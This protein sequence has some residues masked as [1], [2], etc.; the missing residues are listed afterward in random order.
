MGWRRTGRRLQDAEKALGRPFDATIPDDA[1][2]VIE[3]ENDGLP[4]AQLKRK[5]KVE[6]A[7]K[8]S[9]EDILSEIEKHRAS[10]ETQDG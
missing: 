8:N 10:V 5:S 2:L 6:K 1:E 7:I 4:I 9:A 3:A